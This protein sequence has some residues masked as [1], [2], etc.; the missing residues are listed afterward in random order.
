MRLTEVPYRRTPDLNPN[1]IQGASTLLSLFTSS[2][3]YRQPTLH[4]MSP[5]Y[6][7]VDDLVPCNRAGRVHYARTFEPNETWLMLAE[8]AY[9][10]LHGCYENLTL[11]SLESGL[12]DMTGWPT[13]KHDL[14]DPAVEEGD[15]W[16]KLKGYTEY[17][18]WLLALEYGLS[19]TPGDGVLSGHAY[20]VMEM[21][22]VHAD[23]TAQFDA[24]D[25]RMVRLHNPWGMAEW[26]GDWSKG[27]E[28]WSNYP[29]IARQLNRNASGG[30]VAPA[31]EGEKK[32]SKK[33]KA[34]S[35]Y[36]LAA[37]AAI[38]ASEAAKEAASLWMSWEDV[39]DH[40]TC[41]YA[42]INVRPKEAES[43]GGKAKSGSSGE[44][45]GAHRI[46]GR[47]V[48]GDSKSGAGGS[49]EHV[50]W[51][52]NPQYMV[53]V[54][55]NDTKVAVTLSTEDTRFQSLPG[56]DAVPCGCIGFVVMKLTGA[57]V[58]STKFHPLKMRAQSSGF[59]V[60]SS[61]SGV[62]TLKAGR[63]A[64]VPSTFHP[65]SEA[66]NF[67]LEV[68]GSKALKMQEGDAVVDADRLDESD[69]EELGPIDGLGVEQ[70]APAVP[71]PEN[72]GKELEALSSQAGELASL[73]KTL[74]GDIKALEERVDVLAPRE[75]AP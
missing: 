5:R 17:P 30:V 11:G 58:R 9:A 33:G 44:G 25:V 49:P 48:P 40:F 73:M 63:Y 2:Y 35:E 71:D 1:F 74:I 43:S 57:K 23:A 7:H 55:E 72:S 66:R 59:S 75:P 27:S 56:D 36:E 64:I 65:E 28:Q 61:M 42:A 24:L 20:G 4:V 67:V 3:C 47:W 46:R 39:M 22:E 6:V 45:G 19:G 60:A 18:G 26:S 8:K 41:A 12:R 52:Q 38:E 53:E 68:F 62:C 14:N 50:S 13:L 69:D 32:K 15:V 29:E 16:E 31:T 21:V 51:P 70:V 34:K 54:P 10:K 37:D